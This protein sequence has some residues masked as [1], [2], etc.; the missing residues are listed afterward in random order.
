ML[1]F[2]KIKILGTDIQNAK[3]NDMHCIAGIVL[4][5]QDTIWTIICQDG[6]LQVLHR[7]SNSKY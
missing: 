1:P 2:K 6:P 3:K 5:Q 4:R 7:H